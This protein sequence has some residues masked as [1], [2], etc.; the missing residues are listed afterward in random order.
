MSFISAFLMLR[1]VYIEVIRWCPQPQVTVYFDNHWYDNSNYSLIV[2]L[3]VDIWVYSI[4]LVKIP[5]ENSDL[6]LENCP[7]T[8]GPVQVPLPPPKISNPNHT[9]SDTRFSR[10]NSTLGQSSDGNFLRR[11]EGGHF[12]DA[13][14][15][16]NI[17]NVVAN[18]SKW[19]S[20]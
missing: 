11:G 18:F 4:A 7:Q 1:D 19:L 8:L 2:H 9:L 15:N 3:F 20:L 10:R 14:L 12:A 5:R 17:L 13:T 6:L 16:E